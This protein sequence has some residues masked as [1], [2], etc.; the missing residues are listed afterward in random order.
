MLDAFVAPDIH[1]PDAPTGADGDR[2]GHRREADLDRERRDRP[3]R[4][5][6]STVGD[7]SSTTRTLIGTTTTD[8]RTLTD[9]ARNPGASYTYDLVA[10]D[11]SDNVSGSSHRRHGDDADHRAAGRHLRERRRPP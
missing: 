2:R 3:Q 5:T 8:V 7:G 10:V 9:A 6:G 11:T 4:P 1:A